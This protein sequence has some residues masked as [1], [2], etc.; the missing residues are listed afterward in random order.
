MNLAK[1]LKS[2]AE[3]QR[4]LDKRDSN[5]LTVQQ[6]VTRASK[7]A[8]KGKMFYIGQA[9]AYPMV[10]KELKT[11]GFSVHWCPEFSRYIVSWGPVVGMKAEQMIKRGVKV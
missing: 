1:E 10:P 8:R 7:L 9:S 11:M 4:R 2:V 6:V 5:R 3:R